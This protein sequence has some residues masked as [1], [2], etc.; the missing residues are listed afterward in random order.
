MVKK[1]KYP[2]A[3]VRSSQ[4]EELANVMYDTQSVKSYLITGC[5]WDSMIN[6][7]SQH[8]NMGYDWAYATS[9]EYGNLGTN[10][11]T[12]TGEYIKDCY[13][14]IYDI[15]GNV[16]EWNSGEVANWMDATNLYSIRG[17]DYSTSYSYAA[18]R[19]QGDRSEDYLGF[20]VQL[21]LK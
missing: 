20:R 1:G 19:I 18:Y 21:C 8:N 14:N 13:Y 2:Y 9:D 16:M 5:A 3:Y 4:A 15:V 7:I 11:R 12:K 6:Y 17:G 10:S